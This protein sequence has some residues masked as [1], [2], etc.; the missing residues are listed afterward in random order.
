MFQCR[1]IVAV[2]NA[3]IAPIHA[4]QN[5]TE[6]QLKLQYSSGNILWVQLAPERCG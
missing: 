5:Y 1:L 3:A 2:G 6:A 4:L